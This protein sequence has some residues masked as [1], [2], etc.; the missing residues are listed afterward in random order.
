M[1][2]LSTL[3]FYH[4]HW[5]G[6]SVVA[7]RLAEGLATSGHSVTVLTSRHDRT[8]AARERLTGV[9]V[10]RVPTLGRLSRTVVMPTFPFA[11]LRELRR[12]DVVHLHTPM[13]ESPLVA[14]IARLL[15]KPVVITHHGDVVMPSWGLANRAIQHVMDAAVSRGMRWA[16]AIVVHAAD[17]RDHSSFLAPW[18]GKIEAIYPPVVLPSPRPDAAAR[19]RRDLGLE[20]QR[21][22]GFAGRFVEEKG[23]DFLLRAIPIVRQRLPEVRFV[24]AGEMNVPYERFA[25]RCWSLLEPQR[26]LIIELGLLADPQRMADFYAM[27]DVFVLP[28]RTDCFAIVQV[29][30]LLSGTPLVTSDIPGAREVVHATGAGA[31]VPAGD[32]HGIAAGIIRV[33]EDPDRYRPDAATV[34][35]VFDPARSIGAY[36]QLLERVVRRASSGPFYGRGIS[37]AMSRRKAVAVSH[38]EDARF[39]VR[40]PTR[41][42]RRRLSEAEV[43][44]V[45]RERLAP[46]IWQWDY[47]HLA[48]LRRALLASF[49]G[50]HEHSGPVL[51]L[52]C[53]TKPYLELIPWRPVW[54]AD[55]DRHFG[56]AD[57]L[58]TAP[59]PFRDA[60]F[61]LVVCSQALHLVD[62]PV[63]TVREIAR[64][65]RP[66]GHVIVTIPHLF[67][68]EGAFERRWA[69][70][71]LRTLFSGWDDVRIGG[72]DGPGA[73]LAFV[74]G[75]LAML[76]GRR[77][78][79]LRPFLPPAYVAINAGCA[80]LDVLSS[81]FHRRWPH[82][83]VLLA[84]RPAH[85]PA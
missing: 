48:G 21:L 70:D 75:R 31:L 11:L 46:R 42:R 78:A 25:E 55:I 64:I 44:L 35:E 23:F 77:W 73:A 41:L 20:G 26:D 27:C 56:R 38:A 33:L 32:P 10:V 30:S 12:A 79:G 36:E 37:D 5:T 47:L 22:V 82:G 71:D 59:L 68:A 28:S 51:D 18:A 61:G 85:S 52:Y 81:P 57:V 45:R 83:I 17:Y 2:I 65:V 76:C 43:E 1:R 53:G 3:T 63:A 66:G 80:W 84:R 24:F 9:D 29:E 15:R 6:L 74:L 58:A 16:D 39:E 50:I 8:L 19:W 67:L 4:P 72:I 13:P 7:R 40:P 60:S 34:R 54:G 49:R 14:G 69:A 62:D